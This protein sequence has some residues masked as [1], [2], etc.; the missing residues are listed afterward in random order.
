[1]LRD[2]GCLW[3]YWAEMFTGLPRAYAKGP[4]MSLAY[5]AEM[6]NGLPITQ[7]KEPEKSLPTSHLHFSEFLQAH[8]YR[9]C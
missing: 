1:M 9:K 8:V 3:L 2:Q 6:F 5:W 4:G 7:A